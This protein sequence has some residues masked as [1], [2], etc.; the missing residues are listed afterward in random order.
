MNTTDRRLLY[1][2]RQQT[3]VWLSGLRKEVKLGC[4]VIRATGMTAYLADGDALEHAQE[5][6]AYESPRTTKLYDRTGD[7]IT[8]DEVTRIRI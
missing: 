2:L 5:M 1:R 7:E 4:H 3:R 8:L 6:A